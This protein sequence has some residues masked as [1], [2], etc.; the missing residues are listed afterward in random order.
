MQ[1]RAAS[2]AKRARKEDVVSSS[3]R[4]QSRNADSAK[5]VA[6]S[7]HVMETRSA[8]RARAGDQIDCS[9]EQPML[10]ALSSAKEASK[11]AK[12][13]ARTCK[14]P[15]SPSQAAGDSKAVSEEAPSALQQVSPNCF[16]LQ[17]FTIHVH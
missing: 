4:K 10:H 8:K 17:S 9:K 15:F 14:R 6:A 11:K 3:L 12:P 16:L 5:L 2:S 1:T 13:A 7:H